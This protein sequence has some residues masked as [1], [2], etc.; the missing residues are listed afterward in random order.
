MQFLRRLPLILAVLLLAEPALAFRCQGRL[1]SDGDPQPKVLRFCGQPTATQQR[2]I[3]RGGVPRAWVNQADTTGSGTV[4]SGRPGDE[5]LIHD[6]S[7][8][9]VLVEEWTYN[10]GPHR[11]MRV[12]RFE[13]GLVVEVTHLGYG[14]HE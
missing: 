1:I 2:L 5:L 12:V 4:E 13:N 11:L 3:Y 9:E 8:V 14:Y 6:R 10:H 7:V